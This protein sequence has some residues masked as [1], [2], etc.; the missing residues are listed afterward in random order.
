MEH[1]LA[2]VDQNSV[3]LN[4]AHILKRAVGIFT[5]PSRISP[6]F[7]LIMTHKLDYGSRY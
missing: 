2:S 1:I 3:T 4:G 5:D 6:R 7:A